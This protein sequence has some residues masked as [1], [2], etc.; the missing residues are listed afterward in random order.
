MLYKCQWEIGK[1]GY[2]QKNYLVTFVQTLISDKRNNINMD[3]NRD[4]WEK[5]R[6]WKSVPCACKS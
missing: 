2:N 4:K 3:K 1:N 5:N 6:M